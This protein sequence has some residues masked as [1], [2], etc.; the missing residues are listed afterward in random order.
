[1]KMQVEVDIPKGKYCRG[2]NFYSIKGA[3]HSSDYCTLFA[4]FLNCFKN[5]RS[6]V[7]KCPECHELFFEIK[8]LKNLLKRRSKC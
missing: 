4:K 8:F 6:S 5:K 7:I 1:M 3:C 2:C